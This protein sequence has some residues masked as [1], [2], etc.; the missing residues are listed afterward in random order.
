MTPERLRPEVVAERAAWL[1]ERLADLRRLPLDS[2]ESFESDT[3]TP[4]AAESHLRRS[5][6]ALLE[7]GRHVLAK[8]FARASTEYK[9]IAVALADVG[10]LDVDQ[11]QRLR[12]MAGYRD[13]LVHFYAEITHPELYKI[14]TIELEDVERVLDALLEW[15]KADGSR[16]T[17]PDTGRG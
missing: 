8:R 1:R 13:R 3:S 17:A 12:D 2:F 10:V 16:R 9:E 6:E 11:G 14:C 7:L 15:I 5:L 4:A